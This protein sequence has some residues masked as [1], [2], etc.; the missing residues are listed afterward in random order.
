M[1]KT[2]SNLLDFPCFFTHFAECIAKQD[3]DFV[4]NRPLALF[5]KENPELFLEYLLKILN[6]QASP[7]RKQAI[8]LIKSFILQPERLLN[9]GSAFKIQYFKGLFVCLTEIAGVYLP[10]FAL[11]ENIIDLFAEIYCKHPENKEFLPAEL[12]ANLANY[13]EIEDLK[14]R[15]VILCLISKLLFANNDNNYAELINV[16]DFL[17]ISIEKSQDIWFLSAEVNI[18]IKLIGKEEFQAHH[19][20]LIDT[21][22]KCYEYFINCSQWRDELALVIIIRK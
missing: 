12:T 10:A 6:D 15:N 13:K 16:H 19:S 21:L 9:L 14:L 4:N 8:L 2:A 22:L 5:L 7:Y 17:E 3:S 11:F 20:A 1:D 18:C